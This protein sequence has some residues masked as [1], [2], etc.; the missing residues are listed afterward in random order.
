MF[1]AY[2]KESTSKIRTAAAK[3]VPVRTFAGREVAV[4]ADDNTVVTIDFGDGRFLVAYGTA[5]TEMLPG[6]FGAT[7]FFGTRG[8]ISGL[9]LNGEE[10]DYERKALTGGAPSWDWEPQMRVLDHVTGVH[11]TIPESHVYEDIMQLVRWIR[12]GV[13]SLATAEHARHVVDIIESAY[14]SAR[15]GQVQELTTSF[16]W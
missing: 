10:I 15:T 5:S 8:N 9:L 13:P 6:D 2:L 1:L 4:H 14:R 11:T 3:V 16:A 12:E 7:S